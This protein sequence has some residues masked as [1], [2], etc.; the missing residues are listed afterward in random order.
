MR[1]L[2]AYAEARGV[3][4][5]GQAEPRVSS[6]ERVLGVPD[7]ARL[8]RAESRQARSDERFAQ[9]VTVT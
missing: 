3:A 6:W 2:R 9:Y 7:V 8:L 1:G 4:K 5:G